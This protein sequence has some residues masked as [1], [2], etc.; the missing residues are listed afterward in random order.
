M[1][2]TLLTICALLALCLAAAAAESVNRT[3]HQS[4]FEA[5][6]ETRRVELQVAEGDKRVRLSV[7]FTLTGGEMHLKLRDARGRVRQDVVLSRASKYEVGT[8]DMEAIPGL[9][10]V[11]VGLRDATGSYDVALTAERP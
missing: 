8:G 1:R 5:K 7:K 10:T 2:K 3:R 6:T 11:E 4:T 9:W